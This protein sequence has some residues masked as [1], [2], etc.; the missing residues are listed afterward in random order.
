[1]YYK[2][3]K[4]RNLYQKSWLERIETFTYIIEVGDEITNLDDNQVNT[5]CEYLW[6][7]FVKAAESLINQESVNYDENCA[8]LYKTLQQ[9]ILDIKGKGLF[10]KIDNWKKIEILILALLN[11]N[12]A[13][14]ME[15]VFVAV[16]EMYIDCFKENCFTDFMS[17]LTTIG[18]NNIAHLKYKL[19]FID[20]RCFID[21]FNLPS[22]AFSR[23]FQGSRDPDLINILKSMKIMEISIYKD[24]YKTDK[25]SK[26][27][28]LHK[29]HFD[30]R[31]LNDIL[32]VIDIRLFLNYFSTP[33]SVFLI[34]LFSYSVFFISLFYFYF[35]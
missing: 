20:F 1:M 3:K 27:T 32:N 10:L 7:L 5:K 31:Y 25:I 16:Y 28:K 8:G 6:N 35:F 21:Y 12:D 33:S 4:N 19:K 14:N 26:D 29:R 23:V 34:I 11:I 15:D 24:K 18:I 9:L 13:S 30:I 17:S 22:A 2:Q